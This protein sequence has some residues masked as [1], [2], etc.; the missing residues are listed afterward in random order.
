MRKFLKDLSLLSG[1]GDPQEEVPLVRVAGELGKLSQHVGAWGGG[2][3]QVVGEGGAVG[4]G[5]GEWMLLRGC[6][7]GGK[8]GKKFG[9]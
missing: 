8:K 4:G 6:L 9:S 2:D 3:V 1:R 5:A 7:C